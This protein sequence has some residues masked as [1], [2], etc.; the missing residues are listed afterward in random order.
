MSVNPKLTND[1]LKSILP[2]FYE[3]ELIDKIVDNCVVMDFESNT[4]ILR[5]GQFVK[6]IPIVLEGLIKVY[7]SFEDKDLLLYYIQ[8][9]ESCVM[10]FAASVQNDPSRVYAITEEKSKVLLIPVELSSEFVKQYP[11][12]TDLFFRL[13]NQR[14]DDLIDTIN[15]LL[16]HKLDQRIVDYLKERQKLKNQKVLKL[17]HRQI[18]I[19]LGTAREVISRII[20]K[21]E[22]DN[23]IIQ[24][25]NG[26]EVL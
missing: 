17:T 16:F 4:E 7:R 8:P 18:A 3:G 11:H 1:M 13:Y 24:H 14:Y 21:L 26:I 2:G 23:K 25:T 5:E 10:S 9:G 19:E 12:Y 20:K 15:Q 22:N 6:M